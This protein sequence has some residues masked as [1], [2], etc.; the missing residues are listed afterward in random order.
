MVRSSFQFTNPVLLKVDFQVNENFSSSDDLSLP[1][2]LQVQKNRNDPAGDTATVKLTVTIGDKSSQMP[3]Y[4]S[5]IMSANFKWEPEKYPQENLEN[6]LQK[7]APALLLSYIRP[8]IA[9]ITNA[10]PYDV[11]NLPFFDFTQKPVKKSQ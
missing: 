11:T 2:Q 9:N 8:I 5:A 4:L 3:Y 6:L 7:N 10:S 1:I